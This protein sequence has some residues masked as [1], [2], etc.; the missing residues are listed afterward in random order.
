MQ[1]SS[2][3]C[4]TSSLNGID[5]YFEAHGSGEP[6]VLL[7]GFTGSSADWVHLFDMPDL[8]HQYR[9]IA[10]DMRGHGPPLKTATTT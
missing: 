7:H 3:V 5:L 8:A 1:A 9:V 6:L 2:A 10:P 4:R